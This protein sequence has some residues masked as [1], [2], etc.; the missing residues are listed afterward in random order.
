MLKLKNKI[1]FAVILIFFFLSISC[2][3]INFE[4][5]ECDVSIQENQRFFEDDYI[6]ISFNYSLVRNEFESLISL[7]K[8]GKTNNIDV[9]WESSKCK[10]KPTEGWKLGKKYKLTIDGNAR[11]E[12]A[13][14]HSVSI[15][16]IFTYGNEKQL[17]FLNSISVNEG[18]ILKNKEP[19]TFDFSKKISQTSF[20]TNFSISPSIEVYKEYLDNK[21]IVTPLNG[22]GINTY[23]NWTVSNVLSEDGYSLYKEY[24]GSFRTPEILELPEVKSV[25]IVSKFDD[26]YVWLGENLNEIKNGHCIGIEFTKP[27]D[28]STISNSITFSPSLKGDLI[29]V[30]NSDE[31]KY[32]Y[33]PSNDFK[34]NTD[35]KLVIGNSCKD[36]D[37]LSLKTDYK[38]IFKTANEFLKVVNIV[39]DNTALGAPDIVLYDGIDESIINEAVIPSDTITTFIIS[40][41]TGIADELKNVAEEAVSIS[42]LFPNSENSPI[43]T[44]VSWD[45]INGSKLFI[46]AK[47]FSKSHNSVSVYYQ[48]TITGGEGG[49]KNSSGEYLEKS[50]CVTLKT[51]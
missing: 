39:E 33:V 37:S 47:N 16:R 6:I 43:I 5:L 20:E 11:T 23:Y 3:F 45:N 34:I 9:I 15:S 51:S 27:M 12:K 18:T 21:V 19:I 41:S 31:K 24:K 38:T 40:F 22:W 49:I 25:R 29:R 48:I 26:E 17:F 30:E 35:Y 28:F 7:Q 1:L 4:N 46:T 32:I 8:D 42:L 2:G 44:S 36:T 10:I 50:I 13:G 14:V